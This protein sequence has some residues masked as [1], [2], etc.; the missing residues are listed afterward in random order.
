M[1]S[2]ISRTIG[3]SASGRVFQASQSLFTFRQTRL[4]T[5]LPIPSA[6]SALSARWTRLYWCRPSRPTQSK[7]RRPACGA[8]RSATPCSSIPGSCRPRQEAVLTVAILSAARMPGS[9]WANMRRRCCTLARK[10][11][12]GRA[13][14]PF[15]QPYCSAF[16]LGA[17][18][19]ELNGRWYE[20]GQ[21]IM[22]LQKHGIQASDGSPLPGFAQKNTAPGVFRKMGGDAA[23]AEPAP[24]R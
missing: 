14:R 15:G 2:S 22:D 11:R 24:M 9:S 5:S 18:T 1:L 13:S 7:H 23:P 4:T 16:S 17:A 6:N 8:D 21:V 10:K 12:R 19:E 20:A 3:S